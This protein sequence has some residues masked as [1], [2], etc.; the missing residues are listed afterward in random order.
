M[1]A[2]DGP[3]LLTHD[4]RHDGHAWCGAENDSLAAVIPCYWSP[5][6][7]IVASRL[8]CSVQSSYLVLLDYLDV[9]LLLQLGQFGQLHAAC[10]N[11]K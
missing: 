5:W 7:H 1:S 3:W 6:K 10:D 8:A 9:I 4:V 2:S 11:T